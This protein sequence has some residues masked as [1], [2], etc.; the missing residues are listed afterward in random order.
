MDIVMLTST[1]TN[2]VRNTTTRATLYNV[3]AGEKSA[4]TKSVPSL[5]LQI[6]KASLPTVVNGLPVDVSGDMHLQSLLMGVLVA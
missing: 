2:Q 1:I 5:K 3:K 6:Q 4:A